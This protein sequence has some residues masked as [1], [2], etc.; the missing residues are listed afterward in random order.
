[1]LRRVTL[2]RLQSYRQRS[3]SAR[4]LDVRSRLRYSA[5]VTEP[6]EDDKYH[7]VVVFRKGQRPYTYLFRTMAEMVSVVKEHRRR[8]GNHDPYAM[9]VMVEEEIQKVVIT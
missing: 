6:S 9:W 8:N 7:W 5:R 1:M 4:G 2:L 3:L